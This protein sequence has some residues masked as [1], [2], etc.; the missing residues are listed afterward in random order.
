MASLTTSVVISTYNGSKYIIKQLESL[1]DQNRKPDEVLIADD[2]S[3]DNTVTLAQNFINK[4]HLQNWRISVNKQN[5]GWRRNFMEAMWSSKGDLV[6]PCD[7][8]DIWRKDK[9]QIMSSLME[10]HSNIDILTSNYIEFFENGK[11][12]VD[13]WK[14]DRKLQPVALRYNYLLVQSPGCTY[15]VRRNLLNIC[16]KY[17]QPAYPHDALLWRLGLFSN[18]LYT[19]TDTLIKWRNHKT[20]AFAKESHDL[21]TVSA[22]KKWI[23]VSHN[24]NEM[25]KHFISENDYSNKDFE[26][27]VLYRTDEWLRVRGKFYDTKNPMTGLS[28][29]RY[30]SSY[31]RKRQYLGDWYIICFKR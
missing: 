19:Y 17:W 24:F 18:S 30:W 2:C 6:F 1:R 5:K 20:S 26:E 13:P 27:K 21:K 12:R 22:K 8:D 29:M 14:N 10:R 25:L 4:Y 23:S 3:T 31:P 7:Q 28:L 15:C 9:V 16:K 11:E